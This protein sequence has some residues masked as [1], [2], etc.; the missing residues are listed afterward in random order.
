MGNRR[1]GQR[2]RHWTASSSKVEVTVI[3]QFNYMSQETRAERT[4][5]LSTTN[6]SSMHSLTP[7]AELTKSR[8]FATIDAGEEGVANRFP[9]DTG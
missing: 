3:E 7:R 4:H 6:R 8:K 2:W 1:E 5:P 9:G